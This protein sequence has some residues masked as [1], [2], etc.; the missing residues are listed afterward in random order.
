MRRFFR[1]TAKENNKPKQSPEKDDLGD[2]M[3]NYN[4]SIAI[5]ENSS[6]VKIQGFILWIN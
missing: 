3:L 1:R 6:Q 4:F 5:Q 2:L